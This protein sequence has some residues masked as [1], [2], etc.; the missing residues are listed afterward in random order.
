[1]ITAITMA[2][3]LTHEKDFHKKYIKFLKNGTDKP[4]VEILKEIGVDLT[5]DAPFET[6]FKF[7]KELID[8]YKSLT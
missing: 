5:T 2:Y 1:M 8:E 7:I 6:A 4:A 3:R